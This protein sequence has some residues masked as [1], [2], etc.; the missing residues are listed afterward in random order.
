MKTTNYVD[1]KPWEN[2][3]GVKSWEVEFRKIRSEY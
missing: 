1:R 2:F 3:R